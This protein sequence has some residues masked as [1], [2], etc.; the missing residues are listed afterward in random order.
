MDSITAL[1]EGRN[2]LVG[3]STQSRNATPVAEGV[4]RAMS[5]PG[6]VMV[7][8]RRNISEK[9]GTSCGKSGWTR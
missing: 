8:L 7:T 4:G 2:G 5:A 9:V 6:L 1:P 3:W